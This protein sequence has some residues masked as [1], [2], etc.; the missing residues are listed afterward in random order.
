[1]TALW[2]RRYIRSASAYKAQ[3]KGPADNAPFRRAYFS[4]NEKARQGE[5]WRAGVSSGH[6]GNFTDRPQKKFDSRLDLLAKVTTSPRGQARPE[7]AVGRAIP[8]NEAMGRL[9]LGRQARHEANAL[10]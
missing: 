1:M 4:T 3:T 5:P 8:F 9:P 7:S 10:P 2:E 6:V